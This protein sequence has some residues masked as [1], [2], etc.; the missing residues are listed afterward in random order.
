MGGYKMLRNKIDSWKKFGFALLIFW[1][2][3]CIAQGFFAAVASFGAVLSEKAVQAGYI[4]AL[5][6]IC[7]LLIL[8]ATFTM[9]A[10]LR[11]GLLVAP[12]VWALA[13]LRFTLAPPGLVQLR[14]LLFV[15]DVYNLLLLILAPIIFALLLWQA[16][17]RLDPGLTLGKFILPG[18]WLLL[19][20]TVQG[21]N[22]FVWRWS[23]VFDVG[24]WPP[25]FSLVYFLAGLCVVLM[26][27]LRRPWAASLAY[28]MGLLIPIV[29]AV[30]ILGW[31]EGLGLS[32]VMA[33]PFAKGLFFGIWLELLLVATAPILLLLM[34]RQYFA[35]RQGRPLI[36]L[37]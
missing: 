15:S 9:T 23:A 10:L 5:R 30:S 36:K 11:R 26:L 22:Y 20:A 8:T 32:L 13:V 25:P 28:Y 27:A 7:L 1:A 18:L 19:T 3:L 14:N 29:A 2:T 6:G 24:V 31:Y 34:A 4:V 35:W 17:E 16:F 12:L 33:L 37:I 21:S